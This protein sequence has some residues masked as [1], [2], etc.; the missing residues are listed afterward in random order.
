MEIVLEAAEPPTFDRFL[1]YI[2]SRSILKD[3]ESYGSIA[4]TLLISLYLAADYLVVP[5]LKHQ[6]IDA[7]TTKIDANKTGLIP[8]NLLHTIYNSTS[9]T[10]VSPLRR[11]AVDCYAWNL[12]SGEEKESDPFHDIGKGDL[13]SEFSLDL[14]KQLIIKAPNLHRNRI[15]KPISDEYYNPKS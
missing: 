10:G 12:R 3:G 5:K 1:A 11:L 15:F 14:L 2:Y 13:P 7:L 6:V 9:T 4:W 8:S